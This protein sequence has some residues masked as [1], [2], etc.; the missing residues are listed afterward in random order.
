MN[1]EAQ[2]IKHFKDMSKNN[3]DYDNELNKKIQIT[4]VDQVGG[5]VTVKKSKK[6]P[7]KRVKKTVKSQKKKSNRRVKVKSQK[8]KYKY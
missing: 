8:K 1:T 6:K 3:I 7:I 4:E 2:W 5:R